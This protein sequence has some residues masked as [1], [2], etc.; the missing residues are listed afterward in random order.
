LTVDA[1]VCFRDLFGKKK[2]SVPTPGWNDEQIVKRIENLA[3]ASIAIN[4]L[5]TFIII[6]VK[7]A[8]YKS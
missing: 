3:I 5:F 2:K 7:F 4:T 6:A 1:V 8:T